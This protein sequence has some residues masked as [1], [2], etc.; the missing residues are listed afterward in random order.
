MRERPRAHAIRRPALADCGLVCRRGARGPQL[1]LCA[2]PRIIRAGQEAEIPPLS[3]SDLVIDVR[4]ISKAY[5]VYAR[6]VDR[7]KQAFAWGRRQY[8]RE[9]MALDDVS[10]QVRRGEMVGIIGRN[11]SGKSTLLQI[12]AGTLTATTGEVAVNG[13]VAALLELG[14][15][16][17]HEATGVE[18]IYMNGALL[19]L[20]REQIQRRYDDIVAFADIGEF[21]SQPVK[22]YSSGMIVRLAFAVSAHVDARVLIVDEALAVGDAV[23]QAKCFRRI[24]QL[25]RDGVTILLATH[26]MSAVQTLCKYALLL[27]HGRVLKWGPAKAVADEYYRRVQETQAREVPAAGPN[28]PSAPAADS[29]LEPPIGGRGTRV[30]DGTAEVFGWAVYDADGQR[31]RVLTARAP[32][33]VDIGV[34]FRQ[35]LSNPQAGAALRDVHSRMLLGGH[36]MYEGVRLGPVQAGQ[37]C[38]LSFALPLYLNPGTYLLMFGVADH[39]AW[40]AWI[41]CDVFFDFCE[42]EVRG[43]ERAWGLVNV[44]A[45]IRVRSVSPA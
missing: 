42:I 20:S 45:D 13:R 38:V 27:E 15:G 34:R 8:F 2:P 32:F 28:A 22:T 18:N 7:F 29:G 9:F 19:G 21:V 1:T 24:E 36:T 39:P 6:P 30:G 3:D 26:D 17:D 40:D 44:P 4:R 33:R 14:S 12:I 35:A 11:G 16:F 23:F 5:R 31:T 10:L 37:E 43:P 41:D 25:Q